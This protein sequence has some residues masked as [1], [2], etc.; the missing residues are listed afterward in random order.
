MARTATGASIDWEMAGTSTRDSRTEAAAGTGFDDELR[1]Q[2]QGLPDDSE[3]AIW[4][5]LV[6]DRVPQGPGTGDNTS[7]SKTASNAP[8]AV[9][10]RLMFKT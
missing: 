4:Q 8:R 9:R 7:K 5:T 1:S 3:Q 2:Q 6:V 10:T